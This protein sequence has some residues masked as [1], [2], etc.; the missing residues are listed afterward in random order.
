MIVGASNKDK[1]LI[2]LLWLGTVKFPVDR[3]S[4]AV[5]GT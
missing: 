3:S 1:V 4:L 5:C 2:A